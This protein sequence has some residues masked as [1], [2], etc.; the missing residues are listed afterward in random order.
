MGAET[1]AHLAPCGRPKRA[2]A[3]ATE[4]RRDRRPSPRLRRRA[5]IWISGPRAFFR[6]ERAGRR[7]PPERGRCRSPRPC[8]FAM[9]FVDAP[10]IAAERRRATVDPQQHPVA[11]A[12]RRHAGMRLPRR[13]DD[14]GGVALVPPSHSV[15]TAMS[16]PSRSRERMSASTDRRQAPGR[17]A[18]RRA[19]ARSRRPPRSHL[20]D[21][22]E[23]DLGRAPEV[24]GLRDLVLADRLGRLRDEGEDLLA[25]GEGGVA[26][27][28]G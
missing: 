18:G 28:A 22:L 20:N 26:R 10:A 6:R 8:F 25:G 3:C 4:T 21:A 16:S 11:D 13:D 7:P 14:D 23:A 27:G 2:I 1:L 24:E 5:R 15:G 17:A 19:R 9:I 12:R